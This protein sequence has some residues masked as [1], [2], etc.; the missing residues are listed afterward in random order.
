MPTQ[1]I[2]LAGKAY[3]VIERA[4]YERLTTLARSAELP[5]LPAPDAKGNLP[6]KEYLRAGIARN[7]VRDRASAGLKSRRIGRLG[8][9]PRRN[10]SA[11]SKPASIRPQCRRLTRSTGL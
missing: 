9:H 6:A 11:A 10:A 4:E 1:T 8:R 5:P 2:R 7:I 3:V